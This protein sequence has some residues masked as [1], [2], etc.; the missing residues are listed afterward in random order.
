MNEA[1][2][3]GKAE[4]LP[5]GQRRR[6]CSVSSK[7]HLWSLSLT[8]VVATASAQLSL[9]VPAIRWGKVIIRLWTLRRP[10]WIEQKM[11]SWQ[12]QEVRKLTR[13]W[14]CSREAFIGA[15]RP[16]ISDREALSLS[17][18]PPSPRCPRGRPGPGWTQCPSP[19]PGDPAAPP[20]G[21]CPALT[22]APVTCPGSRV[23]T[24]T[25]GHHPGPRGPSPSWVTVRTAVSLTPPYW[26]M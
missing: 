3:T 15:G 21:A 23:T 19:W 6:M 22:R 8:R 26:K 16:S 9:W 11:T 20:P 5:G 24:W 10:Q 7:T 4:I 18:W 14:C 25:P 1:H 2:V 12:G 17:S 13:C